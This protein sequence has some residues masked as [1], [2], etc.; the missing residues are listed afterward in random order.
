RS[1]YCAR[2]AVLGRASANRH[3]NE[4]DVVVASIPALIRESRAAAIGVDSGSRTRYMERRRAYSAPVVVLVVGIVAIR[5]LIRNN[6]RRIGCDHHWSRKICLL[7]ARG[8]FTR[9]SDRGEL[10]ARSR[11]QYA[12]MRSRIAASLIKA[13]A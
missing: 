5:S 9:E 4:V 6:I 13:H 12:S 8:C 10:G 2:D 3:E 11:P 1:R 7:P